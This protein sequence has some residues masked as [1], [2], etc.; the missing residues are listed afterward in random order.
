MG[1]IRGRNGFLVLAALMAKPRFAGI[2]ALGIHAES[3]YYDCGIRFLN[4]M[5]SVVS[6]YTLGTVQLDAPFIELTKPEIVEYC[7]IH[8]VPLE[9]TYSCER[10]SSPPCGSCDSCGDRRALG[11]I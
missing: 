7:R 5:K 2:L 3:P 4:L 10:G 6:D 9:L 8:N 1:E 11:L